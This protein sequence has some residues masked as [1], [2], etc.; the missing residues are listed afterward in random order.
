MTYVPPGQPGGGGQYGQPGPSGQY[1]SAGPSGQPAQYGSAVPG[2]PAQYGSGAPA[3]QPGQPGPVGQGQ[4]G[5]AEA[6]P[7]KVV[8]AAASKQLGALVMGQKGANP[9]GNLFFGIGLAVA[10]GVVSTLIA[11]GATAIHLRPLA[12]LACLGWVAAVIVLGY[13]IMAGLAGFTGTYLYANGIAHVKNGKVAT[14]AWSEVDQLWLWKA[15]GK[16][17]I[18]GTLL[19]Y[20][21]VTLDGRKIPVEHASKSG[22]KT[23]GEQLQQIVRQL[24]RP[25]VDSGP[26][27]G[28]LRP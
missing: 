21:L 28:K 26:Y 13:S 7:P 16:T 3:G 15:G 2:Q 1:G 4:V 18:A 12:Y 9:F 8:E 23:L 10:I 24:G 27:T 11:W 22:D 17:A 5:Q 19:C 25:V 6:P 20:Y 14:A